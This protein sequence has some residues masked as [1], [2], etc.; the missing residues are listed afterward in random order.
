MCESRPTQMDAV[1]GDTNYECKCQEI[2]SKSHTPLRES[3][4]NSDLFKEFGVLDYTVRSGDLVFDVEKLGINMEG[5]NDYAHLHFDLK[6]LIC[7]LFAKRRFNTFF[8]HRT[9]KR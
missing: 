2:V 6:Q 4:L 7:H 3:Y 9:K 5:K 8:S 1:I